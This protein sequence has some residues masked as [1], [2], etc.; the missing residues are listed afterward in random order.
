MDGATAM[1]AD[2]RPAP[3]RQHPQLLRQQHPHQPGGGR[4]R[5][6]DAQPVSN[7][8]AAAAFDFTWKQSVREGLKDVP[9]V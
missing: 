6:E 9:C 5:R 7:A 3:G 2:R 1:V 4:H 8:A